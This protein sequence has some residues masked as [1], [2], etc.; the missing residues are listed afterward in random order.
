MATLI[1]KVTEKCNSNCFYCDVVRKEKTGKTMSMDTL[2]TLFKRVN[3]YLSHP[4]N[5][6]EI[7]WHGGEPLLPGPDYYRRAISLFNKYCSK[8][9]NR[10]NHSIQ[11]NLTCFNEEFGDIFRSLGINTIGTSYDPEPYI[12]GPGKKIDSDEYNRKF[13]R[14]LAILE[15]QGFGWGMIYVVTRKSLSKP[16]EV[17]HFLSN[18]S[19]RGGFNMNPV[20]IYDE[21]RQDIAITPEEFRDFL[22]AIFPVWWK[23]RERYPDVQPFKGLVQTIID[24]GLSLNCGESGDC[25]YYHVN[26]TPDG[27]TSQCGRSA[28][29]GLLQ[30][31]NIKDK[32]LGEILGDAQRHQLVERIKKLQNK[33]CRGCRFWNLCHGGC[34]LDAYS[35][36]KN[37]MFKSEWCESRRGFIEKYFEPVTGVRFEPK[38]H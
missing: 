37:F 29:W 10:V 1:L 12:R 17:F 36:H 6:V 38:G 30:Y 2:E 15:R 34:P 8:T 20:L 25:I 16:L 33:D 28:D 23:H 3:E 35:K 32:S 21:E 9:K 31:G 7:L 13:M 18:L 5:R 26:V 24:G 11:T 27:E 19:L 4:D 22:G 14:A